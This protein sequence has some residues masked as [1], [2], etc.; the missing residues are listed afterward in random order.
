M[1]SKRFSS[2]VL[3]MLAALAAASIASAQTTGQ[4]QAEADAL[5]LFRAKQAANQAAAEANTAAAKAGQAAG[6][7]DAKKDSV[8][9]QFKM[10]ND[11]VRNWKQPRAYSS[12]V[13]VNSSVLQ[14]PFSPATPAPASAAAAVVLA[15]GTSGL[16]WD[17][18]RRIARVGTSGPQL[19]DGRLTA[20]DYPAL[21]DGALLDTPDRITR[22][23]ST[24]TDRS[25]PLMVVVA[26]GD[27][28]VRK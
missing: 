11:A 10:V 21:P 1:T 23:L 5:A 27:I 3:L 7:Q 6:L 16:V 17:A 9:D 22:F 12:S 14:D 8:R 15:L 2:T 26:S 24:C 18:E 20:G 28:E 13:S 25:T 19:C 4:S